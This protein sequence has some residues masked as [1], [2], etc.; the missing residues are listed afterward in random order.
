MKIIGLTGNVGSGKSTALDFFRSK[1]AN[2]IS[3]DTINT[4]LRQNSRYLAVIIEDC[5]HKQ[6]AGD[7]GLIDSHKLRDIIFNSRSAQMTVESILHP[8]IMENVELQLSLLPAKPYCIIEIPL[9]YE[10]KLASYVDSILLITTKHIELIERL[11]A[12]RSLPPDKIEAILNSQLADSNK[13]LLSNDIVLNNSTQE[14]FF[15]RLNQL[16]HRYSQ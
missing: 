3:T 15:E 11:G 16:H 7:S 4:T 9:L 12:T 5:L 1:N 13:F 14:A 2:G 10:A 8:I 6:V